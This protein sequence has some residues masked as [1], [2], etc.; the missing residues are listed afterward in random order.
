MPWEQVV[1]ILFDC[2][3]DAYGCTLEDPVVKPVRKWQTYYK[4]ERFDR[5]PASLKDRQNAKV[6]TEYSVAPFI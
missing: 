4:Q 2:F 6:T 3:R 5:L 1:L